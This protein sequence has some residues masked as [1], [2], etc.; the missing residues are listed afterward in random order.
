MTLG[1][2]GRQ[3]GEPFLV[4]AV[5]GTVSLGYWTVAGRLASTVVDL[6]SAA[7]GSVAGPVFSELQDEPERLAR[8]YARIMSVGGLVLV[9]VMTAMSLASADVVPL[10]FGEQWRVSA[11]VASVL[12]ATWLFMGLV[13]L[14]R[15]LLIGTGR[16]GRELTL[17]TVA[18]VGQLGLVLVLGS[19]GLTAVAAGLSVWGALVLVLRSVVIGRD[20]GIGFGAYAQLLA[21]FL[22]SGLAAAAVLA[23]V[24]PADLAGAAR[25]AVVVGL[26]GA[27]FAGAA[28]LLARP[29]VDD[30]V[31]SVRGALA[32]RRRR[33]GPAGGTVAG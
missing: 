29:T 10:L 24:V 7:M 14:Q 27:V 15:G 33:P 26:G 28:W 1:T 19:W 8:T 12:A 18:L 16:A 32:R 3:S 5:L 31:S 13:N 9:P 6:C 30:L 22:A 25:L 20:L 23:V 2:A 4:G 17:T 21:L 11:Q